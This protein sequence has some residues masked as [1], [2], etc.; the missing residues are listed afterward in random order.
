MA[1]S[2]KNAY[3]AG[4][5]AY[6]PSKVMTNEDFERLLDTSDEWITQMTGIKERHFVEGDVATSDLA[7]EAA[8]E[9]L[10]MAGVEPGDVDV[11][12]VGT[13]TPDML[14]P[15]TA[16]LTQAKIG[17]DNAFAFDM[18]AGCTGF[19]YG[20]VTAAQFVRQG[21]GENVLVIGA[22]VLSRFMDMT[23]RETCVLFGDGAGAALVRPCEPGRGL[24]EHYL[25]SD[26]RLGSLL[27]MPAG[28]SRRPPSKET[29]EERLHYV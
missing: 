26:G 19:L 20:L 4:I 12:I 7:A 28:G 11:L 29:V 21:A 17:A 3:I 27:E 1:E 18:S 8:R 16:C 24:I 14:F 23:K 13:A 9:A 5:G 25:G 2:E 15:S 10:A 22:E 6:V